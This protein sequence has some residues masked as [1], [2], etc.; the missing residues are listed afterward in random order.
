MW[1]FW[2]TLVFGVVYLL[3]YPGLGS[4]AGVL[5]WS[6]TGQY[7]REQAHAKERYEPIFAKYAAMDIPAVAADTQ[8]REMGQRLFLNYCAQCHAAASPI[9]RTTIGCTAA[10]RRRSSPPSSRGAAA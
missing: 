2:I 10:A 6:S 5:K 8:A 9:S 1:L 3:L 4:F 7:E